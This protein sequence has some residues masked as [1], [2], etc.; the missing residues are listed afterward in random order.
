MN[1][2]LVA[3]EFDSNVGQNPSQLQIHGA[4]YRGS[5]SC[6]AGGIPL[7]DWRSID[8]SQ[9]DFRGESGAVLLRLTPHAYPDGVGD[10]IVEGPNPRS[11][12]NLVTDNPEDI[13]VPTTSDML[14]AW[15]QLINHNV[16]LT[17]FDHTEPLD[18]TSVDCATDI[19]C[20]IPF[21]RSEHT[22]LAG[23]RE[24]IN[25]IIS[26]LDA[27]MVYGSD[28]ERATALRE[29]EGGRLKVSAN[30]LTPFNVDGLGNAAL[31]SNVTE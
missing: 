30:D 27:S 10:V 3:K 4:C 26:F 31:P 25:R 24:Q 11:I 18:I 1:G 7:N 19:I 9:E 17:E 23:V 6:P 15:G 8:G 5:L 21:Q 16:G 20:T 13:I 28:H 12:S 22:M 29:L 14:W 2:F